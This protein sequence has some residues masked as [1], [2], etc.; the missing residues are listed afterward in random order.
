MNE[1]NKHHTIFR[2]KC[3]ETNLHFVTLSYFGGFKVTFIYC[4]TFINTYKPN[5]RCYFNAVSLFPP[6]LRLKRR[7]FWTPL[8]REFLFLDKPCPPL[9]STIR[10]P[11][12]ANSV[13]VTAPLVLYSFS[14]C[15]ISIK[16]HLQAKIKFPRRDGHEIFVYLLVYKDY[17]TLV[18]SVVYPDPVGSGPFLT[19]PGK[20]GSPNPALH[21][22]NT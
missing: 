4:I 17:C 22:G 14:S 8:K 9:M 12:L 20:K 1:E 21:V 3:T 16:F 7:F 15:C 10:N 6:H 11:H 2:W 13:L 19:A 18:T 5:K